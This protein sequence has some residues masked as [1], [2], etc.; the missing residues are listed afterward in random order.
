MTGPAQ[1]RAALD[2]GG[3]THHQSQRV[4]AQSTPGA[5]LGWRSVCRWPE[6]F[7]LRMKTVLLYGQIHEGV[8][9]AP[10]NGHGS[11]DRSEEHTSELQSLMRISYAVFC[12][13]KK[14]TINDT[15]NINTQIS[16]K[17]HK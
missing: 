16:Q 17:K 8:E 12:L 6:A 3:L 13:K 5:I 1:V 4:A 9:T 10:G 11:G 2:C 15:T 7:D 14:K